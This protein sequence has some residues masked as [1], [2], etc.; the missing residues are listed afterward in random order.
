MHQILT[1]K[2]IPWLGGF[3]MRAQS[4]EILGKTFGPE[5][6]FLH[7]ESGELVEILTPKVCG[8]Q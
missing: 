5:E 6:M 4:L 1:R 2:M 3:R 7:S 8:G